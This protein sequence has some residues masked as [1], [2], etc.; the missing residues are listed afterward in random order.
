MFQTQTL[1]KGPKISGCRS[2]TGVSRSISRAALRS[3]CLR[4][5][6]DCRDSGL[7]GKW[8]LMQVLLSGRNQ[9]S[10]GVCKAHGRCAQCDAG[11]FILMLNMFSSFSRPLSLKHH[12]F[13]EQK[14][15]KSVA[16][17]KP[18]RA[19]GHCPREK[20]AWLW[21][22]LLNVSKVQSA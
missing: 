10:I 22:M 16:G 8:I 11:C 18:C 19:E 14:A 5:P 15:T 7:F 20:T 2:P 6:M 3:S 17:F 13:A 4:A 9:E 21:Q 12:L 1:V